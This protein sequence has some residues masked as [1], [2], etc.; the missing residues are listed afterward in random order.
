[1][2]LLFPPLVALVQYGLKCTGFIWWVEG[3][4]GGGDGK[5]RTLLKSGGCGTPADVV[6]V[7]S[8]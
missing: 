3:S 6:V 5:T 4:M 8:S 1:L 7:S 2:R